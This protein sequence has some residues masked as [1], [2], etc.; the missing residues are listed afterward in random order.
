MEYFLF[1]NHGLPLVCLF[2]LFSIKY[3]SKFNGVAVVYV[4][5]TVVCFGDLSS[6]TVEKNSFNMNTT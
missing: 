5:F 2:L 6:L 4:S 1:Y 3:D